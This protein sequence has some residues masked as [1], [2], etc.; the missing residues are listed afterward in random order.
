MKTMRYMLV[1]LFILMGTFL[2]AQDHEKFP[3]IEDMHNQKWQFLVDKAQLTPDDVAKVEPVFM[4][5]E[6]SVW[7]LHQQNH[8]FFITAMKNAKKV[9]PNF[10]EL[11]DRYVE[12][13]FKEAQLFKN[14]HMQLRK[15]LAPETLFNYYKAEREFKRKLLQ[16]FHDRR[17]PEK[18]RPQ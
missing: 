14:Y 13:E 10:A 15:L 12:F 11:N 9:K 1:S 3:K 7:Q 6:K 17:P 8:E 2:Q 4:S 16:D 18:P 5:Y